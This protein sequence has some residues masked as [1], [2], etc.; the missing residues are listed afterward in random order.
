MQQQ[1]QN[2]GTIAVTISPTPV[3]TIFVINGPH[4]VFDP[5]Q[6]NRVFSFVFSFRVITLD[7]ACRKCRLYTTAAPILIIFCGDIL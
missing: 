7:T 4:R 5:N 6:L 3:S 2:N 1:K